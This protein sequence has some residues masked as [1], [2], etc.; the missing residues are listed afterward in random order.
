MENSEFSLK[1]QYIGN[2]E[3]LVFVK[4]ERR[5]KYKRYGLSI[6]KWEMFEEDDDNE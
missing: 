5:Q 3:M 2:E 1:F 4:R 6:F